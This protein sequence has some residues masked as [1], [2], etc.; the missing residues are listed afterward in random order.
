MYYAYLAAE[1]LNIFTLKKPSFSEYFRL[2]GVSSN[3]ENGEAFEFFSLFEGALRKLRSVRRIGIILRF[4]A[5]AEV[6]VKADSVFAGFTVHEV[7]RIKLNTGKVRQNLEL[8]SALFVLCLCNKAKRSDIA[9]DAEI[10]VIA[11]ALN[12]LR[13][14]VFN[15]SADFFE[16]SEVKRGALNGSYFARGNAVFIGRSEEVAVEHKLMV[17][18]ASV[19]RCSEVKISVVRHVYYRLAVG[20]GFVMNFKLI[21]I[22]QN[23]S[24][25]CINLAGKALFAVR[26]AV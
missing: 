24:N 4:K 10:V 16:L 18:N 17:K 11:A 20:N 2:I 6:L 8:S 1:N 26:A 7:A 13:V 25:L 22:R 23:I 3:F 15:V 14:V 21:A 9:V 19:R 5:E 12:K